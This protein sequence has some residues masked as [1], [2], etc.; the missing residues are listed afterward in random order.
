MVNIMPRYWLKQL[1]LEKGLRGQ[2]LAKK[3]GCTPASVSFIEKGTRRPG[4][5]LAMRF[6]KVLDFDWT[7]FY[8]EDEDKDK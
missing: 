2:E 5:N 3:V 7:R 4:V 1:R 6:G 8:N